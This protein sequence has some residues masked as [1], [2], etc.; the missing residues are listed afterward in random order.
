MLRFFI[1]IVT[2]AATSSITLANPQEAYDY[3]WGQQAAFIS[4]GVE[5]ESAPMKV[6][7]KTWDIAWSKNWTDTIIGDRIEATFDTGVVAITGHTPAMA[8]HVLTI[9]AHR[10]EGIIPFAVRYEGTVFMIL[11]YPADDTTADG[12]WCVA[13]PVSK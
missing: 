9:A 8:D 2:L 6:S 5:M 12:H 10:D 4:E 11:P 3:C 13:L 1:A 7:G